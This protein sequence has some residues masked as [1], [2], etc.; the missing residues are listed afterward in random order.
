MVAAHYF[1]NLSNIAQ[2]CMTLEIGS[3]ILNCKTLSDWILLGHNQCSLE[4]EKTRIQ[5][6]LDQR[7]VKVTEP[8]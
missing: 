8:L 1:V 5:Y 6:E 2:Q 4:E 3:N 7:S